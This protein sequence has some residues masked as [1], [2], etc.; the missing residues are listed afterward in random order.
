[1]VEW[2]QFAG[3]CTGTEIHFYDS[4]NDYNYKRAVTWAMVMTF[5]SHTHPA[6]K[7]VWTI[8]A[9]NEPLQNA[10]RT[11]GLG[12][13]ENSFVLGTRLIELSL[14]IICDTTTRL[15]EYLQDEIVVSAFKD[16]LPIIT[17]LAFKYTLGPVLFP[18]FP[19]ALP[20]AGE[21]RAFARPDVRR[22]CLATQ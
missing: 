12:R 22:Q 2:Q 6:F 14:G 9:I 10:T 15:S 8:E 21:F 18:S 4:P 20:L 17:K 3:N 11:P 16:A 13:Y 5:L 19:G 7:N 1:M